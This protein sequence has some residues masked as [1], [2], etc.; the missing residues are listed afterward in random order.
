ML[1]LARLQ[2]QFRLVESPYRT[3]Q[4]LVGGPRLDAA[5]LAVSARTAATKAMGKGST[6]VQHLVQTEIPPQV[7]EEWLEPW[8]SHNNVSGSISVR[9]RPH[10]AG[11]QLLELTAL[12]ETGE[13]L[14]SVI[15]ET[16]Q[17][18][19]GKTILTIRDQNTLPALRRRRLMTLL[20]LFLIHRYKVGSVY[21]L[22]PTDDN[23]VQARSMRR[24]GIFT[25]LKTEIGQVIVAEVDSSR[26]KELLTR[27]SG[28]L[29]AFV[30]KPPTS[31][32]EVATNASATIR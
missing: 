16:I 32:T 3:P 19:R 2:R 7:L 8:R 9:L 12:A 18:R 26:V 29:E 31:A 17:D 20:Q 28:A 15:F 6:Q 4:T 24:H 22:T 14:A 10:T 25:D 5:L 11:S 1:A 30:R 27:G 21:Y 23:E 13:I